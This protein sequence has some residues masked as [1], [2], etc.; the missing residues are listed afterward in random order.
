VTPATT[1]PGS[2]QAIH[3]LV[4]DL[5][6][7]IGTLRRRFTSNPDAWTGSYIA[8]RIAC[9]LE[10]LHNIIHPSAADIAAT[11]YP[12]DDQTIQAA[13]DH[14]DQRH[15]RFRHQLGYRDNA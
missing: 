8:D 15:R 1:Q 11:T 14:V 13:I 9:T 6:H 2:E 7:D 3:G 5:A 12:G 4:D 10:T